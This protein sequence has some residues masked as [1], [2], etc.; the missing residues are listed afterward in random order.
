MRYEFV[1]IGG[2]IVGL[3]AAMHLLER[4]PGRALLLLEKEQEFAC[5][6]S[7][8]NSGVVHA[9]VYYAPGSLQARFCRAGSEATLAF[10]A[11][12][13]I[14]VERC[15][16]VLV[17][18]D[19]LE[20][21][22]LQALL[23]RCRQNGIE[24]Q[25]L[26]ARQL[27]EREPHIVGAGGAWV[28]AS[29]IVDYRTVARAM[30][31]VIRSRGAEIRLGEHVEAI[32]EGGAQVT[33]ASAGQSFTSER[34][35]VCAGLMADRL[36]A[37]CGLAADFR[38]VPFRGEYYRLKPQLNGL[39]RHLIY[40]IPKPGLPF[41]GVHLTRTIDGGILA[42]PNAVLSL[43]RE[44]YRKGAFN[45]SDMLEL[46]RFGGFYRLARAHLRAGLSEQW[47]SWSRAAYAQRCRKYCPELRAA[48]LTAHPSGVRAQ[49][50]MSDG[51]L[52]HDFLI[53]RTRRTLHVCNAPSPAATA[54]IPIGRYIA[55]QVET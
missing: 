51:T 6:Q 24:A 44:G 47:S 38:I 9:G 43:A 21:Q 5:H 36:A 1:V 37:W 23:E 42:G 14:P 53:R 32:E 31:A 8:H 10:C 28:P 13:G 34:V 27:R 2:G 55:E 4:F 48:D 52:L 15:G 19:A 18:T 20:L 26:D 41:L 35:I 17:A 39:V 33:V 40:P 22:R 12:H 50:V 45:G 16:K 46:L 25:R 30:A 54:A 7:G 49:V 29:A 11:E 3:S